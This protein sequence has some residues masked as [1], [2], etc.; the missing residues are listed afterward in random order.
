MAEALAEV[1]TLVYGTTMDD[2]LT[3]SDWTEHGLRAL[4]SDGSNALKVGPMATK[5]KVSRGSFYWHFQD[6]ADFRSQVLRS[7][8][9]RTTEQVIRDL[10]AA[11]DEPDRLKHLMR[12][13]F[14]TKR[15]LDRAI[16]SWAAEDKDVAAIVAA[17]DTRRVSYI[18][19]MLVAAG[20]ESRRAL[21]RAAFMYWAYLGQPIVMDPG[22]ASIPAGPRIPGPLPRWLTG[23]VYPL[24]PLSHRPSPNDQWVGF[25]TTFRSTTSERGLSTR[26]QSFDNLQ[27]SEFA[28]H[29]GRSH[30]WPPMWVPGRPW[31]LHPSRTRFVT[32][33][34]IGYASRPNRAIDGR[35][36]SPP[37]SAALL[38]APVILRPDVGMMDAPELQDLS[39]SRH[40]FNSLRWNTATWPCARP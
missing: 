12:R 19:K 10:E 14:V 28:C 31:R 16:W 25:T 2:R 39:G 40:G 15:G 11:R 27:A 5:L 30:R 35:G 26:L 22:H 29:P 32:S 3:K 17:V 21:P 38:A 6:I 18:A 24:L 36:L 13:A 1:N 7:W 34:R 8:Q 20:V 33:P 9:E 23:C 37:R 4:A